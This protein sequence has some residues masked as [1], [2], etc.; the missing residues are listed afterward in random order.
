MPVVG[1][2]L[3]AT[4]FAVQGNNIT[5]KKI[6]ARTFAMSKTP[7]IQFQTEEHEISVQTYPPGASA[8]KDNIEIGKTPIAIS[9]PTI[10]TLRLASYMEGHLKI[11][12]DA[13]QTVS[14][15]LNR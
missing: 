7:D 8:I 13:E 12:P 11:V 5:P 6:L 9:S 10:V 3:L 1:T 15:Q 14:V 4:L 2:V